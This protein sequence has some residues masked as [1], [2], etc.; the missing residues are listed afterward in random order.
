[1]NRKY[2]SRSDLEHLITLLQWLSK[3]SSIRTSS[4]ASPLLDV[5]IDASLM[6]S[7]E[8]A[9]ENFKKDRQSNPELHFF[10]KMQEGFQ[11]ST[12]VFKK[13]PIHFDPRL[14]DFFQDIASA[15]VE[16]KNNFGKD[17]MPEFH[18]LEDGNLVSKRI[19]PAR[20]EKVPSQVQSNANYWYYKRKARNKRSLK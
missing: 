11:I 7:R 17:S 18:V 12:R 2:R 1:M 13:T 9:S 8:F 15:C 19:Q 5:I 4:F 10:D 16:I 14:E 6:I 3:N 20:K